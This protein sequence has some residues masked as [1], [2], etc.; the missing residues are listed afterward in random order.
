MKVLVV[1]DAQEDFITGSL[2]S[3]EAVKVLP[4]VVGKIQSYK[5]TD[6]II[7]TMDTHADNY[8]DTQEG[9]FLPV[10]HCVYHDDGWFFHKDIS[11][12][13]CNRTFD[14]VMKNT[15]GSKELPHIINNMGVG[16]KIESIELVGYVLDIC[17]ISNAILLKA[18]FPEIPITV[19]T[20]CCAATSPE[21]RE[22]AKIILRSCQIGV[23]E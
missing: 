17:V 7:A 21:A 8:L 6:L 15:F 11:D 23:I 1:V 13:L 14:V 5:R 19:D 20:N 4:Y 10:K 2:G 9:K 16:R 22:A 3:E 12:M 18:F